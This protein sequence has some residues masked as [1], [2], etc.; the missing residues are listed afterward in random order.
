M[1]V[2]KYCNKEIEGIHSIYANHVR[3]CDKNTTN[4]DKGGNKISEAKKKYYEKNRLVV[5]HDV[6]CNTCGKEFKINEVSSKFRK[7]KNRFFCSDSC[8]KSRSSIETKKK[9]SDS[10]KNLWKNEEYANKIIRNNTNRNKR[11]TSKGEEEIKNY[12]K[13]NYKIHKWTSG[14]GFK[15]KETILTRD[16]YSNDLKVIVEYDGIWHFK[17]IYGQLEEKQAKD[18]LLEEWVIGND[19]RIVRISDDLYRKDKEKWLTVLVNSIYNKSDK[20]IK[21]Y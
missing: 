18:R 2:C 10:S 6:S 7:R 5:E 20:I 21:I 14:G 19:W 11:F 16:I 13:E 1:K 12:L 15:Y 9:I 8:S 17:D 3:W 4:G